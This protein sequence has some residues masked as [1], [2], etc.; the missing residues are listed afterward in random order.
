MRT[1]GV[2]TAGVLLLVGV[3]VAAEQPLLEC[4]TY[5]TNAQEQTFLH[6]RGMIRRAKQRLEGRLAAPLQAAIQQ[7]AGEI[8]VMDASGG[9][10]GSPNPFDLSNKTVT[11]QPVSGGYAVQTGTA[12][13]DAAASAA[14]TRLTLADDDTTRIA[15]PFA[16]PFYGSTYAD[17]WVNSNGSVT[18]TEGD[19]NGSGSF[20]HFSAGPPAIAGLFADLDPPAS[21]SGVRLLAQGSRVVLTWAGVPVYNSSSANDVQIR[22]YPDG[23]IELAYGTASISSGVVGIT[24]GHHQPVSLVNFASSPSGVFSSGVAESFRSSASVDL[25]AAANRF[26]AT[27]DDAYDYLVIYNAMGIPAASGVVAYEITTRSSGE[28][29]GD[30]PVD[31][32][33]EYGSPR[34]LQAVLNMGP[35]SQYP[36]NPNGIVSSRSTAGDTPV[37]ILAHEAGHLFLSLLSVPSPTGA[38]PPPMLTSDLAHWA[39]TFNSDAS[40]MGGNRISDSGEATNPRFHTTGTVQHYSAV[41]QYLMGLRPPDQVSPT[42][43]VLNSG[44]SNSRFPQT[45][46]D[47]NGQRLDIAVDDLIAAGGRRTPDA[48]VAQRHFRFAF[49]VVVPEGAD[50]STIS[51]AV[52]QV[53]GYRIAFESFYAN[54]TDLRAFATTTLRRDALLSLAPAAGIVAGSSVTASIELPAEAAAT[55]TFALQTPNAVAFTPASVTIPA[56]QRRATFPVYGNRL[57][58]E[59]FAAV[60]EDPAYHTARARIQVSL[61]SNLHLQIVSGNLQ[62]AGSGPLPDPVVVRVTDENKLPYPGLDVTALPSA[63]GSVTGSLV[64]NEAGEVSLVWTPSSE[65]TNTLSIALVSAP[66][67]SVE[68]RAIRPPAVF[69]MGVVHAASYT[70]TVAAGGFGSIF[71]SNLAAGAYGTTGLPFPTNLLG[72]RVFLNGLPAAL[73]F[74]SDGQ[75]NF[76]APANLLPGTAVL[77]V[78]TPYGSSPPV[79]VQ[80][81]AR[82]PGIFWDVPSGYGAILIAGTAN[83]TQVSP[84]RPNDFL[85]I[86]CTGLGN[87][88]EASVKIA[89]ISVEVTYAGP[90]WI[91]GLDQVNVKIPA[92]LPSGAQDLVMTVNGIMTNTVKVHIAAG[93]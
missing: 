55:V 54:S 57:G 47:F 41:D 23:R 24:P 50:A 13:F 49:I 29:Y 83:W 81:A 75:I 25:I 17:A 88:P 60:P 56:G 19:V 78:Q 42:F 20:G 7:D 9:V 73:S 69:S 16:F 93:P 10:A 61:A 6:V 91:Q 37:T 65:A 39:F 43:A 53:D 28:G 77:V 48:T 14:G 3:G 44:I 59:E 90:T 40:V 4:G 2:L 87:M 22:L 21:A 36:V 79:P 66:T 30:T 86:Y 62:L 72:V 92:G 58:V 32:G 63:G 82:A 64:T 45:G 51:G 71:G 74:V 12:T 1:P 89:G 27:H 67:V 52:S 70:Q 11:L 80:I 31:T 76:I 46:V 35:L 5:I 15:L 26:Y 33:R 38:Y 8:A 68:V 85:E 18:F 84:A 34:R